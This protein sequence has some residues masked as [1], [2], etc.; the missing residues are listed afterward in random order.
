MRQWLLWYSRPDQWAI[1][2]LSD[3][4]IQKSVMW[5]RNW[6]SI[7]V[8]CLM[9]VLSAP[10]AIA[11]VVLKVGA[12]GLADPFPGRNGRQI[13]R[14]QAGQWFLVYQGDD[15]GRTGTYLALSRIPDPQFQGDFHSSFLLISAG[16]DGVLFSGGGGVRQASLVIDEEDTL[17]LLWESN[18]PPAVW[19]SRCRVSVRDASDRIQR[20][21]CWTGPNGE[22]GS[23]R[24]GESGRDSY[25]GDVTLDPNGRL[26][27]AYGEAVAVGPGYTYPIRDKLETRRYVLSRPEG[28]EIWMARLSPSGWDRRRLTDAGPARRPVM[29]LDPQGSLHLLFAGERSHLYYLRF[30]EFPSTFLETK[31]Y[32][33]TPPQ[34]LWSGTGYLAL[35]VVGWGD[36]ALVV[37]ERTEHVPVC[38]Y[39]DG[40][41]WNFQA[42]NPTQEIWRN[43]IL[44]RDH[45]GVAWLFWSN[46]TRRHTFYARWLGRRFSAPYA[47]RTVIDDMKPDSRARTTGPTLSPFHTVQRPL[48]E[49]SRLGMAFSGSDPSG[50]VYFDQMPIP[51]LSVEEGR[52]VLFLDLAEVAEL[53]GLIETFHPMR[54][55]PSNPVLRTGPPGA[56]DSRRAH[57]Y[58]EVHYDGNHFRMWYSAW[59]REDTQALFAGTAGHHVGYAESRDG[60]HWTKPSL[61]QY[62]F[63]GSTD[64]NIVDLGERDHGGHAY[65]PMVVLDHRESD[66]NRRYKMIVEQR[67]RNLLLVSPDGIRWTPVAPVAQKGWSDQRSLFYDTL[68]DDP[69]KKWKVYSHC[70]ARAPIGLR[71][72]C[73]DWSRDLIHWTS[74]PRNPVAHPRASQ[75]VEYHLISVWIDSE[76]YLGL[77]DGWTKT[78]TQPQYL[79]ASR[80][81][82]NFVHVFDGRPVIEL[83]NPGT[84]DSGWISPVN[85]PTMV[86][87]EIW[88]YYSGSPN[89]IGPHM[90]DWITRPMQTGLATI[91][92]D[93]FVSLRVE[94]GRRKGALL[95]I[96]LSGV[97]RR[98]ELE[99]NAAGL[100][101]GK[102][103]IWVDTLVDDQVM[104]TSA[105]LKRDGVRIPVRWKGDR[106][107][108]LPDGEVRLRFRLEGEAAL[109]SFTLR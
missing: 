20:R 30:T 28:Y 75:A 45:H 41:R 94:E 57:A 107:L 95:T 74:D 11:I 2:P 7:L 27:V 58:G 61:G 16:E 106:P 29:D 33:A 68:E 64:N 90:E 42:V 71:K 100:A 3:T 54:K 89:S 70:G 56:P 36:R 40:V 44:V 25:L 5:N 92:K 26:W 91:R 87:D 59:A 31:D 78:Q 69:E 79:M 105:A 17:H 97:D 52:K 34:P 22:G 9:V 102:G 80:D 13:A 23:V 47:S 84:W 10:C 1:Q 55:H 39:Y 83:G 76:I 53:D 4:G 88:V 18:Q 82:V 65:M 60:I 104:G 49:G 15:R 46:V 103:R 85:V 35:S 48:R 37:F 8:C 108:L 81:G 43:P 38:G 6:R 93:G 67:G 24:I 99:I 73:R 77:V 86:G 12:S 51:D 109:Y 98:L 21:A 72:I 19:Y 96:P 66:P 32:T 63:G 14:N 50:A 62:E 101:Q